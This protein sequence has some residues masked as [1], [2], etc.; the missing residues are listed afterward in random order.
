MTIGP[1]F[2]R[3]SCIEEVQPVPARWQRVAH[4]L[5]SDSFEAAITDKARTELF[6]ERS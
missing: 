5:V 1:E 2:G 6:K 3:G 4:E